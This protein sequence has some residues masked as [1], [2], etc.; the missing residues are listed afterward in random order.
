MKF[1]DVGEYESFLLEAAPGTPKP[2]VG[3]LATVFGGFAA[4][5]HFDR[6]LEGESPVAGRVGPELISFDLPGQNVLAMMCKLKFPEYEEDESC[7][8]PGTFCH[9]TSFS[10]AGD[11][12]ARRRRGEPSFGRGLPVLRFFRARIPGAI[13]PGVAD[14]CS[15]K[16]GNPLEVPRRGARACGGDPP[17]VNSLGRGRAGVHAL[18]VQ[19][20]RQCPIGRAL[21]WW[22]HAMQSCGA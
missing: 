8:H 11:R 17:S 2:V 16:N 19:G 4:F 12:R 1:P 9:G 20:L 14:L 6:P 15:Y 5:K 22:L 3:R 21:S 13:L 7:V 10:A 18:D